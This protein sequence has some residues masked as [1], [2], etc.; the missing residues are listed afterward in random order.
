MPVRD[1]ERTA[2]A[3]PR[4]MRSSLR[5]STKKS[6]AFITSRAKGCVAS[7]FGAPPT[8]ADST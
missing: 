2:A 1:C 5:A 8:S 7:A 4:S 3:W 6:E